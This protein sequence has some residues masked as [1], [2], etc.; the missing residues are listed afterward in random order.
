MPALPRIAR[1]PLTTKQPE[2]CPHCGSHV[3]TRRGTRK[4]KLEIVQLW[5]CASC[6][7]V[8]TPGPAALRNKTYPLRMILSA[9]TDYDTGHTLQATAVRLKKK[10]N[11]RVSPST[12]AAWLHEYARHCSYRR[13][14]AQGLSR[15]PAN[16]TIRSIKLYHRQVYSFS[17][18]RAKI[19]FLKNGT[20]DDKRADSAGSTARFAPLADFLESIPAICPHALFT[21]E[22]DLK[23]RASQVRPEFADPSRAIVNRKENAATETAA[24]IIP[25]VGNNK[26]RHETLQRFM[27]ANDSVTLAVEIPIWLTENDIEA[28]EREYAIELAPKTEMPRAITGHIDFL[29]VRNGA[30]HILDYKPDARTNKPI[31]QLTIYALALSKLTGIKLFDIKCAW[32]NEHEYCEFFP[33]ALLAQAPDWRGLKRYTAS[34]H[35]TREKT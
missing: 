9:L 14:R 11:R 25:A 6:K 34:Q 32:F 27:L 8:F 15:F 13:L 30:V 5:R 35:R 16:Q 17:Y 33:R 31:A 2:A 18:H 10:T 7:R 3:L 21:R 23:A 12:I 20:L 19:A 29:Q 4:K 28:I 1:V 26:L 24:L 22:E